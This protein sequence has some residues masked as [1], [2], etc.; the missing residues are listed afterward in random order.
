M[1]SKSTA[2]TFVLAVAALLL[3][4]VFLYLALKVAAGLLA[5]VL[6]VIWLLLFL[7]GLISIL[8]SRKKTNIKLLW[9][10]II[11]LAPVFGSLLWFIWG[12]NNT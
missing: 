8:S 10:L 11:I 6:P 2:L 1:R 12:R 9:I 4:M 5:F 3:A 7:L